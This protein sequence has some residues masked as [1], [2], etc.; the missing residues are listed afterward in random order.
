MIILKRRTAER[1]IAGRR[2]FNLPQGMRARLFRRYRPTALI[3]L[4]VREK[5]GPDLSVRWLPSHQAGI[6]IENGLGRQIQSAPHLISE[7][8]R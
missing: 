2:A 1:P 6:K 3:R 5:N 8:R 4:N 7:V